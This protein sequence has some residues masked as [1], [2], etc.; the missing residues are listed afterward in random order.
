MSEIGQP[1]EVEIH[2][3]AI[4]ARMADVRTSVPG[5]IVSYDSAEQTCTVNAAV[6]IPDAD[7]I[8]QELPQ[9][10]DVPVCQPR[11]GGYFAHFPLA[12]GDAVLISFSEADFTAWR[13]SGE[14]SDPIN[15]RRHGLNAYVIL[16]GCVDGDELTSATADHLTIGKDGGPVAHFKGSTIEL[17]AG[18]TDFVALATKTDA[19]L[20]ALHTFI[21]SHVHTSGG[22]GSP[23][24]PPSPG[25]APLQSVAA[26]VV[27]AQ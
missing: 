27:K 1:S 14:V 25:P 23:T 16:G 20:S 26:T 19:A 21:T 3:T 4:R 8:P 22:P 17:G 13:E 15:V 10:V 2:R 7:G 12:A 11:G 18:V 9:L 5:V 6:R 24:S